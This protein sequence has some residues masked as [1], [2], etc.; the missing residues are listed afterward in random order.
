MGTHP[1]AVPISWL[2]A[3]ITRGLGPWSQLTITLFPAFISPL[4]WGPFTG[5]MVPLGY[6][7]QFCSYTSCH[8]G[9]GMAGGE[10]VGIVE[11]APLCLQMNICQ[12]PQFLF[13]KMNTEFTV[14]ALIKELRVLH[15][16]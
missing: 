1:G 2:L 15:S 6:D 3:G 16:S 13:L 7:P 12:R 10:I 4:Q 5:N 9:V 14:V 11:Q 8:A